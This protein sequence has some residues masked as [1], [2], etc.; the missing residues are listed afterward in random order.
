VLV[1]AV[2]V[3]RIAPLIVAQRQN[4]T[5]IIDKKQLLVKGFVEKDL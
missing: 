1:A 3:Q 4:V 2:V 5:T